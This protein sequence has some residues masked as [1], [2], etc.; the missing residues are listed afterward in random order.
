[1]LL[2]L[3]V[4][5]GH[6]AESVV[7]VASSAS[8]STLGSLA[9]CSNTCDSVAGDV[10]NDFSIT[11]VIDVVES[12][13]KLLFGDSVLLLFQTRFLLTTVRLLLVVQVVVFSKALPVFLLPKL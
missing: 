10:F 1:M 11:S 8:E 12:F 6:K 7:A 4:L 3:S 5:G 2:A 13:D 9:L